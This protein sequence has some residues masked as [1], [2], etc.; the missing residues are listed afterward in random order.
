M[1]YQAEYSAPLLPASVR[2]WLLGWLF[3]L[4]GFVVLLGCAATAA[5][6]VSWTALDPILARATGSVARNLMGAPGAIVSDTIVQM[7][8]LAGIFVLLPPMFWALQLVTA[9]RPPKALGWKVALAPLAVLCMAVA[10]SSLPVLSGSPLHHGYGGLIGD[11]GLVFVAGLL[12][13]VNPDRSWAVAGLFCFAA[14]TFALMRSLGLTQRDLAAICQAP[15]GIRQSRAWW[16][17]QVQRRLREP[18]FA[19][20]PPVEHRVARDPPPFE[21]PRPPAVEEPPVP[22]FGTPPHAP[23][24][25]FS[26]AGRDTAFDRLTDRSS[27][28]IARRFA[29]G[30]LAAGEP[31]L[32]SISTAPELPTLVPATPEVRHVDATWMRSSL[33]VL[34]RRQPLGRA[35]RQG[36]HEEGM[37]LCALLESDAF[38]NSD[39]KLPLALGHNPSGAPVIADLARMPNLL[40]AAGSSAEKRDAVNAVIL[41][42]VYRQAP[43]QCQ[44]MLIAPCRP[45]LSCY[46][47]LPH[48]A[49]PVVS[50]PYDGPAALEWVAAQMDDRHARMARLGVGNIDVFNN[51]VGRARGGDGLAPMTHIVVVVDELADLM[52]IARHD[53]ESAVRRLDK[54]ARAAGIH[55][56]MATQR[57]SADVVS[58]AIKKAFPTRVACKLSRSDSL[59]V[60]EAP[61]ADELSGAGDMLCWSGSDRMLRVRRPLVSDEDV[62]AIIACLRD[63]ADPRYL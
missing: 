29:P 40:V 17:R 39:A 52:S 63:Q 7:T 55:L 32:F 19:A 13:N 58:P 38:R 59:A 50:D 5:S 62:S 21:P 49:C 25:V 15:P 26:D 1:A 16:R 2:V 30:V 8:G 41:S 20:Q 31:R 61:G 24:P 28:D 4:L 23:E 48:L 33:G 54:K 51:R 57:P 11:T 56:V 14:G 10:L 35:A 45:H 18:F 46:D 9:G 12:A 42:L 22:H 43:D 34:K 3:R 27:Q 36:R 44:L 37:Q 47:G 53:V 6:L 60:L